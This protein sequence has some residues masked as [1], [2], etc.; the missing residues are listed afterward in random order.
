M[1]PSALD[2]ARGEAG[3][4]QGAAPERGHLADPLDSQPAGAVR[5]GGLPLTHAS[6]FS[7]IGGLDLGLERAG[8]RTTSFSEIE[9][10]ANAVL[11]Q[12]WPDVPNLGSILDI[13]DVP[14][15]TLWT[16]GFPCQ[17]LSIAGKRAGLGGARSG[18]A[19]TYLDLVEN[20]RPPIILLENVMGLFSSN[21]GRDLLALQ[22]RMAALGYMGAWRA[23]DAQ[24][25]GVAQRRRRVFIVAFNEDTFGD[26]AEERAYSVFFDPEGSAGDPPPDRG[27]GQD[28]PRDI[29]R[30]V[31][32]S[33]WKRHDPD[34]DTYVVERGPGA[35][36]RPED[37]GLEG[38]PSWDR[39]RDG[40]SDPLGLRAAA[41]DWDDLAQG[42]SADTPRGGAPD[43]LPRRLDDR[44]DL[45]DTITAGLA[46]G[47]VDT[48]GSHGAGP[49]NVIGDRAELLTGDD[50]LNPEGLDTPRFKACG[51]GVVTP[52]AEYVGRR[53]IAAIEEYR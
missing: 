45:A 12:H 10:Y 24:W 4:R 42:S 20:H 28:A 8:W 43:G 36:L 5:S 16:G 2:D 50:P 3:R 7:G 29:A 1:R 21:G 35:H 15:A 47:T 51:N 44:S 48:A 13:R 46:K 39:E 25:F 32:A 37:V 38:H 30:S 11:A 22:D 14:P 53:I 19:L 31:T 18:L 9:P 40:V 27:S 6:F 26:A 49:R 23:L 33:S 52:V 17:D 41:R 34:T